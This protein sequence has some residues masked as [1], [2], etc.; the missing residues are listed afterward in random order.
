MP[1]GQV[2]FIISLKIEIQGVSEVRKSALTRVQLLKSILG[3]TRHY[4]A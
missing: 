2:F 1:F 3:L 4:K